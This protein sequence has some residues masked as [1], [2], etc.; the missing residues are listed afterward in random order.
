MI[1]TVEIIKFLEEL[2]GYDDIQPH[3]D[4]YKDVG[5]VGDD[6]HEMIETF[7]KHYSVDMSNYLWYFH[8]DEEGISS[9]GSL[10]FKPPYNRV[11]RIPITPQML[12]DFANSS[13]WE[14]SYPPHSIPAKRYDLLI[15]TIVFIGVLMLL[16]FSII[17]KYL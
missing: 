4:I 5:M 10:F 2:S 7:A 15:N 3:T 11:K 8:A 13:K 12:T 6:F 9:I 14:I 17:K 1:T 16:L